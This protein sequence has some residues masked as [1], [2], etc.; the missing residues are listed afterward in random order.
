MG[1]WYNNVTF[2]MTVDSQSN[3]SEEDLPQ[4]YHSVILIL[5]SRA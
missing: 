4:N 2:I 1:N 5:I 3:T